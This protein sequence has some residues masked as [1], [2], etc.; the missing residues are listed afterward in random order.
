MPAAFAAFVVFNGGVAVGDRA[1][2]APAAHWA[3]PLYALLFT[4]AAFAP[5][6]FHPSRCSTCPSPRPLVPYMF[7]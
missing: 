2:H 1:N 5:V 3:Q 6:H 4:A 7:R